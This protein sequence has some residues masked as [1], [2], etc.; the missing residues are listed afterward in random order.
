MILLV[1]GLKLHYLA[2]RMISGS[3]V[4]LG[5]FF[6]RRTVLFRPVSEKN[7]HEYLAQDRAFE[8]NPAPAED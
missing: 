4:F 8:I 1:E 3:I 5:S 6:C 7:L 2:A